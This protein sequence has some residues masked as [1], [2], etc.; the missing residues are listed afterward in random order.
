MKR[1]LILILVLVLIPTISLAGSGIMVEQS[2]DTLSLN[3]TLSSQVMLK[4]NGAN[5]VPLRFVS[6]ALGAAVGYDKGNVSID[7]VN[8]PK[9]DIERL[10]ESCVMV[11]V[12]KNGRDVEQ[13]SGVLIG[14]NQIL[15][16]NHITN[17]GDTYRVLYNGTSSSVASLKASN[18]SFDMAMLEP[19]NKN[20]K[21]CKIGD[22]DELK[23]GDP[24]ILVS[25]P[26]EEKNVV[27]TGVVEG[28]DNTFGFK[29]IVTSSSA[30]NGSS[31]GPCFNSSGELIG[32]LK[33]GN[34]YNQSLIISINDIRK[35][36]AD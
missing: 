36:L 7:T 32:V 20:V 30:N 24:V 21:P 15:S 8:T 33:A 16:V 25:S 5:Y 10:K 12:S 26:K 1:I 18:T 19:T 14:W 29:G 4:H 28:F 22:S 2:T 3:G 31:G 6:E 13:G 11:Y 23:I 34:E 9:V 27:S 17:K 35:A